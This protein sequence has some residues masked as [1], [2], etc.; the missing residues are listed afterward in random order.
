M[1]IRGK[2]EADMK[3]WSAGQMM[4]C[5]PTSCFSF[6]LTRSHVSLSLSFQLCIR[7]LDSR[8]RDAASRGSRAD[9]G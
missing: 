3:D 9:Q 2:E 4:K 6:S 7:S 8:G 5:L 1:K